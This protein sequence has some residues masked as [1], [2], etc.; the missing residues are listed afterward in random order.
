VQA[1]LVWSAWR[2]HL[3][4]RNAY[5]AQIVRLVRLGAIELRADGTVTDPK[6]LQLV[7]RMDAL[8]LPT[9]A[10]QDFQL[11][12]FGSG[13]DAVDEVSV[14]HPKPRPSGSEPYG[15]YQS[16]WRGVR[17]RSGDSIRRIQKGDA[18]LESTLAFLLAGV[19]AGYGIWTAVWGLGGRVGWLLVPVSILAL[20]GALR[21]IPARVER[22]IRERVAKLAAFRRY[23]RRFSDLPNAPA[24]AVVIWERYLEWAVALGV[25][26]EVE[27]QVKT[28]VPV[29]QL[30]APVPGGPGGLQGLSAFHALNS[31]APVLVM[32]SMA[33]ASTGGGSTGGGFGSSSSSSGFSSGGF[34]SGG[35]G[36]GG[37]TG[38]R[39]G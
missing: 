3:S 7:R 36:G 16:W 8:E 23:L 24:M 12:L 38:G 31:A 5:R 13:E 19:A 10:D 2:G 29:E 39:A 15:R 37:G 17:E 25:A 28:L 11:L 26:D 32:H 4:P 18:R 22:P 1:A 27:K 33:S 35:G 34:S 20:I 30:R 21:A 6:D 14:S 9:K